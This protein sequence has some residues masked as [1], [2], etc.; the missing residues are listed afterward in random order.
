MINTCF[1]TTTQVAADP[2]TAH[3]KH[4]ALNL[5]NYAIAKDY[6]GVISIKC[7][8]KTSLGQLSTKNSWH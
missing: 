4:G 3:F 7:S 6:K 8:P 5:V 2:I 1:D